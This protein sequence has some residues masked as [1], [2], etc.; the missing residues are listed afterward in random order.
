MMTQRMS[1]CSSPNA[2]V[3]L[4]KA[5]LTAL[6]RGAVSVPR[7]TTNNTANKRRR[8]SGMALEGW[9]HYT[10]RN[11]KVDTITVDLR[12]CCCHQICERRPSALGDDP[13]ACLEM[14]AHVGLWMNQ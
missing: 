8:G 12:L 9:Q 1:G 7:Q 3:M 10:V 14:L 5:M 2:D 4:G 6:S 13:A 11:A